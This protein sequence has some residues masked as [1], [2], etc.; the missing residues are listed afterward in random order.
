MAFITSGREKHRCGRLLIVL[1]LFAPCCFVA[2]PGS[3]RPQHTKMAAPA[4][5]SSPAFSE[6]DI[7]DAN[8]FEFVFNGDSF[9]EADRKYRRPVFGSPDWKKHRSSRRITYNLSTVF[10]SRLFRA[11]LFEVLLV[12]IVA[13]FA[14][15]YYDPAFAALAQQTFKDPNWK[16]FTT[17]LVPFT[18][19]SFS[20]SLLLVFKTNSSYARWW[21]ARIIWGGIVNTSRDIVRQSLC[22]F[23]PKDNY[24][25]EI[26]TGLATGYSKVLA[27]HLSDQTDEDKELLRTQLTNEMKL[28]EKDIEDI[29]SATHKPMTLNGKLSHYLEKADI[30]TFTKLHLDNALVKFS[31][32]Y[33]MCERIY[34]TPIPISYTRLTARFLSV[35][36]LALPF[37]LYKEVNPHWLI[38]P[39]SVIISTFIFGIEELGVLIE[40]PFSVLPLQKMA[41]GI[42]GSCFEA[43]EIDKK[44]WADSKQKSNA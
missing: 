16:P 23:Q 43:L 5:P 8:F 1:A 13:V 38:V 18:L 41:D 39:A 17:S 30:D 34:K 21:E 10:S 19:T 12:V 28:P 4:S 7:D 44:S 33:G 22:R 9:K 42:M 40:E 2:G 14:L 6:T 11:I 24:L 20:L 36:L 32:F 15:I 26:M 35:W 37:A 29:M 25:K 27:F 31:D 3:P